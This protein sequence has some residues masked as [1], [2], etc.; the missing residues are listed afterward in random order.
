MLVGFSVIIYGTKIWYIGIYLLIYNNQS[1]KMSLYIIYGFILTVLTR[2]TLYHIVYPFY[3]HFF[4]KEKKVMAC[5]DEGEN[6]G[7]WREVE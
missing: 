1:C 3:F 2:S 6:E 4:I 5:L 7:E